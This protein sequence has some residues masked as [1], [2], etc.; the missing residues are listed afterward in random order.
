MEHWRMDLWNNGAMDGL[1]GLCRPKIKF[2]GLTAIPSI[3][4]PFIQ[5][6]KHYSR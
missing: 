3:Q 4:N 6:S 1:W 5:K 2:T